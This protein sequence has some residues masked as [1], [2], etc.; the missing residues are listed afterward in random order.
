[1]APFTARSLL[2]VSSVLTTL[3]GGAARGYAGIPQ[4]ENENA[5]ET[6]PLGGTVRVSRPKPVG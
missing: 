4:V 6:L 2:S 1:M 3:D 5:H